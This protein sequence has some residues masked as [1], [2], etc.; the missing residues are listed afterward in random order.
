MRD[1]TADNP[2]VVA[3]ALTMLT[4]PERHLLSQY[5]RNVLLA[6]YPRF[7]GTTLQALHLLANCPDALTAA[8]KLL[9]NRDQSRVG[10]QYWRDTTNAILTRIRMQANHVGIRWTYQP[11]PPVPQPR[12]TPLI[13]PST[14]T[15]PAAIAQIDLI[16]RAQIPARTVTNAATR[17]ATDYLTK[18][19]QARRALM[20]RLAPDERAT[21]FSAVYKRVASQLQ[22]QL[23]ITAGPERR[24]WTNRK[25][26]LAFEPTIL[27]IDILTE[28]AAVTRKA[29]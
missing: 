23:T 14:E 12:P 16:D 28:P 22:L 5:F 11:P 4:I 20:I 18:A 13:R 2:L 6:T 24:Q 9:V 26:K 10:R 25:G 27:Y 1:T 29:S 17:E 3:M 21:K 15:E 7:D 19:A 8:T